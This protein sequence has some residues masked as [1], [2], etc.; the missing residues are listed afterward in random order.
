VKLLII[1]HNIRGEEKIRLLKIKL[2][3][4]IK[5]EWRE[6]KKVL[7][8][9]YSFRNTLLNFLKCRWACTDF[10]S[11]ISAFSRRKNLKIRV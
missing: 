9:G 5:G 3:F 4:I 8:N 11:I 1:D 6:I 7:C 2:D 10:G